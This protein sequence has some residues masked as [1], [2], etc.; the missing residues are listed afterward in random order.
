[1]S[2]GSAARIAYSSS[3]L[4]DDCLA[5]LWEQ[6]ARHLIIIIIRAV[7]ISFVSFAVWPP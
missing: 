6:W 2:A 7:V 5:L 1:M 3:I 4:T